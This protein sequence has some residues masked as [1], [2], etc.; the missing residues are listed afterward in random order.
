MSVN[1]REMS[2]MAYAARSMA[3]NGWYGY[4]ENLLW[5]PWWDRAKDDGET[6]TPQEIEEF[7][8]PKEMA[9]IAVPVP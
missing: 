1:L 8:D 6:L 4:I 9:K 5:D 2:E 3:L 7:F